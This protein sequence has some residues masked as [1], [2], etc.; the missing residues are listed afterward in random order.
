MRTV[1][2]EIIGLPAPQ[3]SKTKLPNGAMVEGGSKEARARHRDWRTTVAQTCHDVAETIPDAPFDEPVR[4]VVQFRFPMPASRSMAARVSGLID[5]QSAPDLDKLLRALGD[6]LEAGG[7]LRND[8]RISQVAATKVEVVGWTG[9][10][11]K[12]TRI[13]QPEGEPNEH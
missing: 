1:T 3:G 10:V 13:N 6:G 2:F 4:L 8:A 5:K 12:L 7:L 11:V 9:A